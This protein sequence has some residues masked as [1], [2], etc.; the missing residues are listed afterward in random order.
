[1]TYLCKNYMLLVSRNNSEL[2]LILL[3]QQIN[4]VNSEN[5]FS[6]PAS[7]FCGAPRGSIL[8]PL[9]FLIYVNGMSQA[10]KCDPF[11][12]TDDT[13]L[14]CQHKDINEIENQLNE[15]FCNK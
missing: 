11:L 4:L 8:G 15:Y 14:V 6:Q 2:V 10:V 7:V 9:L 3:I 5:S 1:M 12:N 13:C